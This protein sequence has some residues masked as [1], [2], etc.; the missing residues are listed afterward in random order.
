MILL[1]SNYNLYYYNI[2]SFF[3]LNEVILNYIYLHES[4]ESKILIAQNSDLIKQ[5]IVPEE[6]KT[7]RMPHSKNKS[8]K[9][10]DLIQD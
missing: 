6:K 10:P 8:P 1:I 4:H 2:F 9:A 5:A 7:Y 3:R